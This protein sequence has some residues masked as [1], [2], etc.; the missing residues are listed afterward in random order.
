M[1]RPRSA[2]TACPCPHRWVPKRDRALGARRSRILRVIKKAPPNFK[3]N[4]AKLC[5][6]ATRD[7]PRADHV[8]NLGGD[9]TSAAAGGGA[10]DHRGGALCVPAGLG[11]EATRAVGYTQIRRPVPARVC[12]CVLGRRSTRA[13]VSGET[14]DHP[15][16]S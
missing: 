11:A 2:Q 14:C 1:G 7:T 9:I 12:V 5:P 16:T 6:E 4:F 15:T 8:P 10:H 13:S 3:K